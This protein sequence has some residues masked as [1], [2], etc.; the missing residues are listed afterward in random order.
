[1]I[2]DCF[3]RESIIREKQMSREISGFEMWQEGRY[4]KTKG[5]LEGRK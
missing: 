3:S 5:I 1:L 2:G 4:F